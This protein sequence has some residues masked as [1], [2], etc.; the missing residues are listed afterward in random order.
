MFITKSINKF[1]QLLRKLY[2]NLPPVGTHSEILFRFSSLYISE[3]WLSYHEAR[4]Q[5]MDLSFYGL[6]LMSRNH[7]KINLGMIILHLVRIFI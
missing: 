6:N 5:Y 1:V 2:S 4:L 7:G 3:I